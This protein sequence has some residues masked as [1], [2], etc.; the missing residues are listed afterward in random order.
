MKLRT[1]LCDLLNIDVPIIQ[2][3]MGWDKEGM[4]TPPAASAVS[5]AAQSARR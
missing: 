2:A 1:P 4:T 3:G 5:A